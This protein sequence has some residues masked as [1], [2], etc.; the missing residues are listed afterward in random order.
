MVRNT[1]RSTARAMSLTVRATPASPIKNR[2]SSN[3]QRRVSSVRTI[4]G[5]SN[6]RRYL[7]GQKVHVS[8]LSR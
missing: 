1:G 5:N 2:G 3:S 8:L 7:V 4:A 6:D